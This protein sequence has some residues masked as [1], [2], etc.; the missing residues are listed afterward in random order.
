[1]FK[2][3]D[4]QP[5]LEDS[6]VILQPLQ[7]SDFE[8]L[9]EVASDAAIWE[10]HP[11][12]ERSEREGFANFFSVAMKSKSAFLIIDKKSGEIIGT[13]R[14]NFSKESSRAIEVGY[15]FLARKFWGGVYNKAIKNLMLA[16]AFRHF[17]LVLFYIDINNFRSQKAVEKIGG[18]RITS[19][20]GKQLETRAGASVIYS[21]E[22]QQYMQQ[23]SI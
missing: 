13:S 17:D 6:L 3:F 23:A 14:Y 18:Q 4:L 7:Q 1:M 5:V 8:R 19:I 15:T 10:Q 21:I 2:D 16:H 20:D 11:A 22:W 9:F 12:K